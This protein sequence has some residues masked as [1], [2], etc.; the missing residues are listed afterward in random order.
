M[1]YKIEEFPN[2]NI[3]EFNINEKVCSETLHSLK[4]SEDIARADIF[5]RLSE[6]EIE[7]MT[8]LTEALFAIDGIVEVGYDKYKVR[9]TKAEMF[10][11]PEIEDQVL[12]VIKSMIAKGKELVEMPRKACTEADRIINRQQI[13]NY[14][15]R[16]GGLRF[17][18]F[19]DEDDRY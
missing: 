19:N 13:E 18:D 12:H 17:D 3:E 8:Y 16:N 10:D 9:I 7:D 6:G 1:K 11:W 4:S 5:K 14:E 15:R 2:I